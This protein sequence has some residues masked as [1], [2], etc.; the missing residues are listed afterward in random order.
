ML[1]GGY[2]PRQPKATALYQCVAKHFAEFEAVYAEKYQEQIGFYRP[3]VGKVV[4]KFLDCG[5]LTRGFARIKCGEC[6]HEY[7][8]AVSCKGRYFSPSCH[9]KRV[10]Q[11]GEWLTATVL[12]PVA[13]RQ[14][15]FTI[16]KI[17]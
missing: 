15:V 8:L 11:F 10:L 16:P 1:K 13:R 3:V 17:L 14:Y 12:G 5:D 7:L 2:R 9:Q 4:K 6:Q